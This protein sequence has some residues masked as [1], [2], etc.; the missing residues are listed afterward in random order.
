MTANVA[1]VSGVMKLRTLISLVV[2]GV[3]TG[4]AIFMAVG[5]GF[6]PDAYYL[7]CRPPICEFTPSYVYLA[8]TALFMAAEGAL[9]FYALA[10]PKFWPL[11]TR[12][13][14]GLIPLF[15]VAAFLFVAGMHAPR[16]HGI[17]FIWLLYV[18]CALLSI[19]VVGLITGLISLLMPRS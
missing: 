12:A 15:P 19:M 3:P 16:F 2:V 10:G 18:A 9:V 7:A 8:V 1:A 11:W 13:A 14:I 4:V 17:H 5:S 6:D